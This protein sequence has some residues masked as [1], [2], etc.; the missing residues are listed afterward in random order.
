MRFEMVR[1]VNTPVGLP[2]QSPLQAISSGS[3]ARASLLSSIAAVKGQGNTTGAD[4]ATSHK[5]AHGFGV[6]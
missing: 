1:A 5:R 2:A 4:G 3:L 6:L